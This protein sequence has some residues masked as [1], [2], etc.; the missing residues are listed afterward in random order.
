[1]CENLED[2]AKALQLLF[3][4]ENKNEVSLKIKKD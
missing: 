2:T 3:I 1:M 4:V